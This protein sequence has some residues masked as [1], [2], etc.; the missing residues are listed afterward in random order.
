MSDPLAERML[1]LRAE[2][3]ADFAQR[4]IPRKEVTED[5]LTTYV[6]NHLTPEEQRELFRT[7][8]SPEQTRAFLDNVERW[9]Q[10]RNAADAFWKDE[11]TG[12]ER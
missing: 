3:E 10:D 12:S 8:L 2:A 7:P 4:G 9:A 11:D 1:R 5:A 6:V